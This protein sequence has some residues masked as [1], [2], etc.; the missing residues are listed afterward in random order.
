MS[1]VMPDTPVGT[2]LAL[3]SMSALTYVYD[4]ARELDQNLIRKTIRFFAFYEAL[5]NIREVHTEAFS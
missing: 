5:Y 1:A 4:L 3:Q 2:T